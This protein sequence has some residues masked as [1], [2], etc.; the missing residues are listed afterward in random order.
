MFVITLRN[1][2]PFRALA[3]C[4][5]GL[6]YDVDVGYISRFCRNALIMQ[7]DRPVRFLIYCTYRLA[8]RIS[9]FAKYNVYP[10]HVSRIHQSSANT[11]CVPIIACAMNYYSCDVI[12]AAI[13]NGHSKSQFITKDKYIH[14]Y[15]R[16]I[17]FRLFW[18]C[19]SNTLHS[20]Y[21]HNIMYFCS[22]KLKIIRV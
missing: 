15:L 22:R 13:S 16:Y 14:V 11:R 8:R 20:H 3:D 19:F 21:D 17:V 2:N 7:H 12:F 18:K 9:A 1:S 5:L 6:I 10:T 4:R